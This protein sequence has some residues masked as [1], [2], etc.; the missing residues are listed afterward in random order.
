MCCVFRLAFPTVSKECGAFNVLGLRG[1]A[2]IGTCVPTH[3]FRQLCVNIMPI[4][5]N[6]LPMQTAKIGTIIFL[7]NAGCFDLV[8]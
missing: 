2:N 3:I 4:R 7:F 6:P 1:P 8:M 5:K